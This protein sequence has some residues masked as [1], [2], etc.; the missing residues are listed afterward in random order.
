MNAEKNL[1]QV[2]NW[3]ICNK[4][5]L[6]NS[7]SC[8]SL[9][10]TKNKQLPFEINEL[11]LTGFTIKRQNTVKHIGLTLDE[12]LQWNAHVQNVITKLV[13]FFG[14]FNH[15]KHFISNK[16]ARQL[17]FAF[18]YPHIKYGIEAYGSCANT[19]IKKLQI[20][21]NKLLK[22]LLN[23][24]RK[25]STNDVHTK[26]QLLKVNDIYENSLNM[27]VHDCQNLNCPP[28]LNN[29]FQRKQHRYNTRREDH[30]IIQ[31]SRTELGRSRV[32][33]KAA[34]LWNHLACEIK[35]LD[36]NPFKRKINKMMLSNYK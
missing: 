19:L 6:N 13:K 12:K 15:V 25:T 34:N 23:V 2:Q 30:L 3:F 26:L 4:L 36:R 28:I 33:I 35:L 17:Y 5:T 9:Y 32:N 29:Y 11:N 16:L 1:N 21:Q 10:H 14:I 18:I 7:K 24:P 20:V 27:F 31:N 22:L 8:F